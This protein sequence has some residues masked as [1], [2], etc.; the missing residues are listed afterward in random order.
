MKKNLFFFFLA[1]LL[2]VQG[3]SQ[4]L[5]S[6][7]TIESSD[8]TPLAYASISVNT[9]ESGQ[10]VSGAISNEKG[11]FQLAG[12]PPGEYLVS[13]AFMG[14]AT[15][16]IPVLV[17][18]LNQVLDLGDIVLEQ[19]AVSLNEVGITAKRA[20]VASALDKK[21]YDMSDNI[22]QAGGSVLDAM[23]SM[24]GITVD[25]EG[26][27]ILRGSDKVA[28]LIDGKQS[29]LT[30]FGN[31]K[32][33]D[34]IPTS[35]IERIEIIN[36]PSAK[37]DAAGMAGIVNIIYKKEKRSGFNG[38]VGFT[39]GMGR[40]SLR[41]EDLPTTL[42]SYRNNAKYIPSVNLNYKQEKIH[43][44]LQSSIVR[45]ERL[46]NNEFTTR[47]YDD[48][49]GYASQVAENRKQTHYNVKAGFDWELNARHSLTVLGVYDYESHRDTSRIGYYD[50]HTM[51]S[52]RNWSFDEDEATGFANVSL[53]HK[54]KFAEPGHELNSSFQYTKGW[55]DETYHLY[56]EDAKEI[57]YNQTHVIAP[58]H[59]YQFAGDYTRPLRF[60]RVEAGVKGQFRRMPI[61]YDVIRS[62]DSPIYQG[63]GDW[64]NWSE[65]MGSA[66]ANLLVEQP[67]YDI[68]AGLRAEYT[69]VRYAISEENIYYS[70]SVDSY[71]YFNLFPNIRF[72]Y[73]VNSAHR[74]SLFYNKRIDRPGEGDL[75][76][77]PK[78]DDPELLKVGNPYLR[79]QYTQNVELAYKFIWGGGS[80]F[81]AGYH[82]MID[83]S[84]TR[85]YA[86]DER[87]TGQDII[88]KVYQNVGKSTN[89][90]V[91]MVF[92]Q[93][94][95]SYWTL[96]GSVNW[97]RNRIKAYNGIMYFPYERP[98][99]IEATADSPWYAKLNSQLSVWKDMKIQL[100]GSY[101]AAKST[102]QGKELSRWGVDMGVK[103]PFCNGRLELMLSATDLFNTMG[104]RQEINGDGFRALYENF[105]ETQLLS[106]G[107]KVKL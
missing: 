75:R 5:V 4:V 65:K 46:P 84:F 31:Q 62:N 83:D 52:R 102:V 100:S 69:H 79:P 43:L 53:A 89:T 93:Q 63:L 28:I 66:Y 87:D 18:T 32:G 51:E 50:L 98:F 14:Y 45:Q 88:N 25:Q 72:T 70:P 34:N 26:K 9:K 10:L 67:K 42:S 92:D 107:V 61:T 29:G 99:A 91:E 103:K 40:L 64:S 1:L 38:D 48:G 68:E 35:A 13:C 81:V 30:G 94:L 86:I 60:G 39:Y 57:R 101:F 20:Q 104:I 56:E 15:R 2:S 54:Y 80:V 27:V 71:G 21:S 77:F 59:T 97:Y 22:A 8:K 58:E 85:I 78:Y 7:R 24:P 47:F 90:G 23:K 17:G 33:L 105:Y 11:R 19:T 95:A 106:I 49:S 73:K 36:N 3:Y 16:H 82:K 44:F 76:I 96:S 41:K 6:G 74:L 12:L 55:E 37:Y